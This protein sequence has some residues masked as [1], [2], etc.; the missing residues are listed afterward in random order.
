MNKTGIVL[1]VKKN[2]AILMTNTGEFVKVNCLRNIPKIG[3]NYTGAVKKEISYM[4]KFA[5][6][7]A[8]FI[9]LIGGGS[10]YAYVTPIAA[11][12]VSINP[13]IEIQINRFDKV[14][15][16]TPKNNDGKTLINT[17]AINNKNI[18]EALV[19]VVEAAKKDNFINK[20]YI[21]AGKTI[22]VVIASKNKNEIIKLDKFNEFIQ[23]AKI[24]TTI[25]NNGD[26]RSKQFTDKNGENESKIIKDN[27]NNN[28]INKNNISNN[29]KIDNIGNT[30][31]SNNMINT[32][33]QSNNKSE[34]NE[35]TSNNS[36]QN[37]NNGKQEENENKGHVKR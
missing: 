27:V 35:S 22:S 9:I 31:E 24:N 34:Y 30:G 26:R 37:G 4:K 10:T 20:T 1:E 33:D 7:I 2:T 14:I 25:D 29:D 13:S 23:N 17:L 16:V 11:I 28:D 6:A 18:D 12:S 36:Q 5:A 15:K 8:L 19:L 21:E 3:E 32:N